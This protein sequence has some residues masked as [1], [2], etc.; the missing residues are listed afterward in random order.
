MRRISLKYNNNFY[1]EKKFGKLVFLFCKF[2]SRVR[3]ATYVFA[4]KFSVTLQDFLIN[5]KV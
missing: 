2:N 1:N 4:A 3:R 5:K